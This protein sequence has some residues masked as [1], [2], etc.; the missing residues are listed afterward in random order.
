MG[1]EAM[2]SYDGGETWDTDNFIYND[3]VNN[4]LGYPSTV[5][6]EDGS[7]ITVF[8]AKEKSDGP[9]VIMQTHWSFEK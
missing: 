4:D 9:C 2:F 3:K 7:L 8:Y 1:I 6:L 5:E